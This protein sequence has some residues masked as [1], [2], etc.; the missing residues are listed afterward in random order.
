MAAPRDLMA[1]EPGA[2]VRCSTHTLGRGSG[3]RGRRRLPGEAGESQGG[4]DFLNQCRALPHRMHFMGNK[5]R[6][7]TGDDFRTFREGARPKGPPP[8]ESHKGGSLSTH[9]FQPQLIFRSLLN[10]HKSSFGLVGGRRFPSSASMAKSHPEEV[11]SGATGPA[12]PHQEPEARLPSSTAAAKSLTERF[13]SLDIARPSEPTDAGALPPLRS[14]I[15][16][17]V[18]R[19]S[20]SSDDDAIQLAPMEP[21]PQPDEPILTDNEERFCLLPVK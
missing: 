5:H 11:P 2:V 10:H 17:V 9:A 3:G 14:P 8:E 6:I 7:L 1:A 15:K 18:T 21:Q 4:R 13:E 12:T 19:S 20:D 16:G